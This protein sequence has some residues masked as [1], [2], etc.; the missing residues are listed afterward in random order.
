LSLSKT[1][2]PAKTG[3]FALSDPVSEPKIRPLLQQR[4]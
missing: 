1:R 2:I 4:G 3:T